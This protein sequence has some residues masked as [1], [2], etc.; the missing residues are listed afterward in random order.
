[1]KNKK[2]I[3]IN[4]NIKT[5]FKILNN[6]IDR[7][8]EKM[9][10]HFHLEESEIKTHVKN[11]LTYLNLTEVLQIKQNIFDDSRT[12]LE[13]ACRRD[14]IDKSIIQ[15]LAQQSAGA[16]RDLESFRKDLNKMEKF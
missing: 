15:H 10:V 7:S 16:Q 12:D 9:T 1:M 11:G 6:L 4:V 3:K 14:T 8:K 5:K 13:A 2:K